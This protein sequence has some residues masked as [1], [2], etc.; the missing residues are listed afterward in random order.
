MADWRADLDFEPCP[1]CRDEFEKLKQEIARLRQGIRDSIE[2]LERS[3]APF[4]EAC[5]TMKALA[6]GGSEEEGE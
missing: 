3:E 6:E 2:N 1:E 4:Y 5:K